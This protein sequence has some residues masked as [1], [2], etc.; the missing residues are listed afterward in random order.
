MIHA[1][2]FVFAMVAVAQQRE[3]VK[4][5]DQTPVD[6]AQYVGT[7]TCKGCHEEVGTRFSKNP[8]AAMQS[9]HQGPQWQGCEACHGPGRSHAEAGDPSDIVRFEQ[10]SRA[11]ISRTC[12][13]CHDFRANKSPG[14]LVH[15]QHPSNDVGCLECHSQHSSV[16]PHLLK[17]AQAELC[18]SCH[19]RRHRKKPATPK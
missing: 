12:F 6:P 13:R 5:S 17:A 4:S 19:L 10:L 7:E 2:I 15:S 14:K 18:A 3:P 11:E 8:H 1:V 9:K 16:A